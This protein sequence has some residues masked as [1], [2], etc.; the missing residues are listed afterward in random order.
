MVDGLTTLAPLMEGTTVVKIDIEGGEYELVPRIA[1][2]L[3]GH[4]PDLLLSLHG[5]T[6][7]RSR[8]PRPF[9]GISRRALCV[10]KR[11]RLVWL[12]RSVLRGSA[13]RVAIGDSRTWSTGR[14]ALLRV[15]VGFDEV[16]IA[17]LPNHSGSA[18][19]DLALEHRRCSQGVIGPE[20]ENHR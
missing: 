14:A 10:G 5:Y 16:E 18:R 9:S 2:L 11:L 7:P 1:P 17:V 4:R 12:I 13:V 6:V 3:S 19:D 15:L 20:A 8:V